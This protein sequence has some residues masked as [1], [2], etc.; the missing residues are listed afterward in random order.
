MSSKNR[1]KVDLKD[2]IAFLKKN[3]YV[4]IKEFNQIHGTNKS[5]SGKG[6]H[7]VWVHK[8]NGQGAVTVPRNPA[9]G[10]W[11]AIA[12]DVIKTNAQV[13]SV[14]VDKQAEFAQ[15]AQRRAERQERAAKKA[16]QKDTKQRLKSGVELQSFEEFSNTYKPAQQKQQ[17]KFTGFGR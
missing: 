17:A 2:R 15:A 3:N 11:S 6:S 14:A 10:T 7:E 9:N 12:S 1:C 16:W 4:T 13:Q 8:E 5:T